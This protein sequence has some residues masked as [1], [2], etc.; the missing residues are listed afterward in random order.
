MSKSL[1]AK[2]YEEKKVVKNIKI[3]LK[4]ENKKTTIWS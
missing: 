4:K 1:S 2:Y 3:F